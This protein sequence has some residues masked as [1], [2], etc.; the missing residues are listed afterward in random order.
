[1]WSTCVRQRR[2]PRPPQRKNQPRRWQ[3]ARP[4]PRSALSRTSTPSPRSERVSAGRCFKASGLDHGAPPPPPSTPSILLE[5]K[6]CPTSRSRPRAAEQ[7]VVLQQSSAVL[8]R[9]PVG[10]SSPSETSSC[11]V[12]AQVLHIGPWTSSRRLSPSGFLLSEGI[13]T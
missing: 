1:M 9:P 5:Q 10:L 13:Q 8:S 7:R 2:R 4:P 12:S 11:D 3:A 6:G